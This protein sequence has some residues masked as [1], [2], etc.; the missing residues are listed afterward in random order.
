M[1]GWISGLA[2][3][4]AREWRRMTRGWFYL[5]VM[6]MLP[7]VAGFLLSTIFAPAVLRDLPVAICDE[8]HSSLS[9]RITRLLDATPDL[10]VARQVATPEAGRALLV[11]GECQGFIHLPRGLDRDLARKDPTSVKAYIVNVFLLPAGTMERAVQSVLTTASVTQSA[12]TRMALGEMTAAATAAARP[13]KLENH[14]LFNPYLNYSYFLT[15]S[16]L[17]ALLNI[18]VVCMTIYNFGGEFRYGTAGEWLDRAGGRPWAAVAGKAL[19]HLCIFA[20]LGL[21]MLTWLIKGPGLPLN[22][23]WIRLWGATLVFIMAAQGGGTGPAGRDRQHAPGAQ[24]G[25][26]LYRDRLS[27]FRDHLPPD[28]HAGSGPVVGRYPAP[29]PLSAGPAVRNIARAGRPRFWTRDFSDRPVHRF[30]GPG[31]DQGAANDAGPTL[32]GAPMKTLLRSWLGEYRIIFADWGAILILIGAVLLYCVVYPFPYRNEVL[33]DVPLAVVDLDRSSLSRQLTRMIDTAQTAAVT[34]RPADAAR[35]R[36]LFLK[37]KIK[38]FCVIPKNFGRMLQRGETATVSG[39]YDGA[40][41]Y[42]YKAVYR[43]LVGAT[44]ALSAQFEV[45]SLMADGM[46][47]TAAASLRDPLPL[48]RVYLF[49]PAGG[50]ASFV[51]PAIF[52]LILQQTLLLGIGLVDGTANERRTDGN[53]AGKPGWIT[54]FT[55]VLG[56]SGAYVSGHMLF[57]FFLL[58]ILI[59]VYGYPQRVDSADLLLFMLPFLLASIFLAITA[60]RFFSTRETALPVMLILS[61]PMVF[62]SGFSWPSCAMPAWLRDLSLLL[63]ST[64]AIQG[65]FRLNHMGATL[66]DLSLPLAPPLDTGRRLLSKRLPGIA[67]EQ[68]GLTGHS[69]PHLSGGLVACRPCRPPAT[70]AGHSSIRRLQIKKVVFRLFTK[71]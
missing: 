68:T 69:R 29:D 13:I 8:D 11:T 55:R 47:S 14:I 45:R 40:Y 38:G 70:R 20:L 57:A 46:P 16:L 62:L 52:V 33:V 64:T 3:S 28:R 41:V 21:V 26:G 59:R 19:V 18:L 67:P 22:G 60:A 24:F 1:S 7:L 32:L 51:V 44:T 48:E 37:G 23:S 50:Y 53:A 49:N 5:V 42:L 65:F 66:A 27:L 56:R 63:P 36:Q 6:V 9:R 10:A 61:M 35:A 43:A 34:A 25:R 30:H 2:A 39:Y 71:P 54:V 4:N 17:P 15:A 12:G 58:K 31:H